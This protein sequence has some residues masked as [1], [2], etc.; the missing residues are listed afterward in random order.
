MDMKTIFDYLG[1]LGSILGIILYFTDS[2]R[3][4][5]ELRKDI[6][7][8]L[9]G[10]IIGLAIN[11][12]YFSKM[13][14]HVTRVFLTFKYMLTF[15]V[16]AVSISLLIYF[17]RMQFED[18]RRESVGFI[19][20]F[21]WFIWLAIIIVSNISVQSNLGPS[22]L[23]TEEYENLA[24]YSE[25]IKDYRMALVF[26]NILKSNTTLDNSH[27]AWAN[28]FAK[29]IHKEEIESLPNTNK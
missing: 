27:K 18:K 21:V 13:E 7:L 8:V 5:K 19:M 4:H 1:A 9:F 15:V 6:S 3:E 28:N 2:L 24:A 17:L 22:D 11:Y 20:F 23:T 25:K 16:G 14:F 26:L 10:L 12:F 29:K